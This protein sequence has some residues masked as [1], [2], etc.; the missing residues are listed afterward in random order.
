MRVAHVLSSF[1]LGGQERV[2]LDLA[3]AQLDAG[4]SV[5]AIS[6]APGAEGELATAFRD[7]GAQTLQVGRRAGFDPLLI[8]RLAFLLSNARIDVVH[9]HNPRALV[10]GAPAARLAR[11][12]VIHSKH[13]VNPDP[14][15]RRM[16]R[17]FAARLVDAHVAVVLS[18]ADIALA[19]GECDRARLSV[20]PNGIDLSRFAPDPAARQAVRRELGLPDDVWLIGTVGRLAT[21]KDHALLL[22]ATAALR[23]ERVQCVIVG[24]G[25]ERANLEGAPFVHLVGARSDVPRWLAAF[26][27]FA[28]SSRSEGL[29]LA[30]IEG[31]ATALPVVATSVGGVADLVED[32]VTGL[33]VPAGDEAALETALSTLERDRPRAEAMGRTG[34][35]RVMA[36]HSARR[37]ATEYQALYDLCL[38]RRR[39]RRAHVRG[40]GAAS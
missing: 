29:P 19:E 12:V 23:S 27:V 24:D 25:P 1:A 16:L 3:K 28:L 31:M 15:R 6:L 38:A 20:I 5:L 21:E 13:G 36:K 30:L 8:T 35:A 9:T 7:C 11:A 34:R 2:A 18:L 37:M 32:L 10:Y 39:L 33:L 22:R 4:H 17:R 40:G 26:D 14:P